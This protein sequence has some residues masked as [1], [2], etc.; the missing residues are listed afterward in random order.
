MLA[1]WIVTSTDPRLLAVTTGII[2][3]AMFDLPLLVLARLLR[4]FFG[5][6]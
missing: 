2:A 1:E 4:K 5:R 6:K 3:T